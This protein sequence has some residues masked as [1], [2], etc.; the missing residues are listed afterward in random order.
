[1]A[2]TLSLFKARPCLA[3]RRC[4]CGGQ[5][6]FIGQN[7]SLRPAPATALSWKAPACTQAPLD[8]DHSSISAK[9]QHGRTSSGCHPQR[10]SNRGAVASLAEPSTP[11]PALHPQP[12]LGGRTPQENHWLWGGWMWPHPS[13]G[14]RLSLIL[15]PPSL[16]SPVGRAGAARLPCSESHTRPGPEGRQGR[17]FPR[18]AVWGDTQGSSPSFVLLWGSD[19]EEGVLAGG[20]LLNKVPA[21]AA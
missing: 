1:M 17:H 8:T 16:V 21:G 19:Q 11:T 2:L 14:M 10:K 18:P 5:R 20:G 4:A 7:T 13:H 15:P 6:P 12:P 9:G 3:P